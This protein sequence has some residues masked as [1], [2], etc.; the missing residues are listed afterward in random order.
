M[1]KLLF[2]LLLLGAVSQSAFASTKE[3]SL[4]GYIT[5]LNVYANF[6]EGDVFVKLDTNGS[7]C[8]HGYFVNK[9][10]KGYESTLSSLLS[11]FHTQAKIKVTGF[12]GA[13]H[14]WT[15]NSGG[16]CEIYAVH[17]TR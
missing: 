5:E 2:S 14:K 11:A 9:N 7:N 13:A 16:T 12:T 15:G 8:I 1:S 17:F 10:S 3:T 4:A 6:G